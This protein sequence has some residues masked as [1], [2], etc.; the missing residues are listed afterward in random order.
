MRKCGRE[1]A[2][3]AKK[4]SNW[5]SEANRE[6][7]EPKPQFQRLECRGLFPWRSLGPLY[8]T[9]KRCRKCQ[10]CPNS[11]GARA[12]VF[13]VSMTQKA[14]DPDGLHIHASGSPIRKQSRRKERF[15]GWINGLWNTRYGDKRDWPFWAAIGITHP[16]VVWRN[17]MQSSFRQQIELP[18]GKKI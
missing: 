16:G 4:P 5:G 13:L 15:S 12:P 3:L 18:P 1:A 7:S 10:R 14:K 17:C 11:L 2:E 9:E 8:W 6:T